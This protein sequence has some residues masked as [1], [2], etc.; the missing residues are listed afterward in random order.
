MYRLTI[1][2]NNNTNRIY[3]GCHCVDR[4]KELLADKNIINGKLTAINS[5]DG[6]GSND[7][8]ANVDNSDQ[9]VEH[10]MIE[11]QE[12]NLDQCIPS[13]TNAH[14]TH[15]QLQQH[16]SVLVNPISS[17]DSHGPESSNTNK[18]QKR[19][20]SKHN[21]E[22]RN[23]DSSIFQSKCDQVGVDAEKDLILGIEENIS[24]SESRTNDVSLSTNADESKKR[25]NSQRQ[26][27]SSS[28]TD[29]ITD[30]NSKKKATSNLLIQDSEMNIR[31]EFVSSMDIIEPVTL[32][33][34]EETNLV[35]KGVQATKIASSDQ[36]RPRLRSLSEASSE[37]IAN[38]MLSKS[39]SNSP[40]FVDGKKTLS[41]VPQPSSNVV[42]TSSVAGL[43]VA[44]NTKLKRLWPDS[45]IFAKQILKWCPPKFNMTEKGD[46][47]FYGP[48]KRSKLDKKLDLIPSTFRDSPDIIKHMKPHILEEG[49]NGLQQEFLENSDNNIWKRPW[50]K[51]FLR[52]CT[53][54][55]PKSSSSASVRLHEFA[56]QIDPNNTR[57]P[58][59]LG[60]IF[61]VYS[62]NWNQTN[63]CLGFIGSN[64][65]NS[66][67][68]M[69]QKTENEN[70]FDLCKL[71]ISVS[72]KV[73][74]N[75][76]WLPETEM[77]SLIVAIINGNMKLASNPSNY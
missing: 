21:F 32:N 56:F 19:D 25:K 48:I 4:S 6:I 33:E 58:T 64:D 63:C 71:W 34:I 65:I 26:E 13:T 38:R 37:I 42:S 77:V 10:E 31:K 3:E 39:G 44:K 68:L 70:S 59:N 7:D 66:T 51:L 60:E 20:E 69:D 45:F 22:G 76:G 2:R 52:N 43:S 57:P 40:M 67:F 5:T 61:A 28:I 18:Q 50:Y 30:R 62:P 11:T 16:S 49:I 14:Q 24:E 29:V 74:E 73:V 27:K 15:Q 72:S 75:S 47:R 8:N 1:K 23:D 12:A 17:L 9:M 53:P 54:V 55:E 41:F 36:S 35:L 46:I